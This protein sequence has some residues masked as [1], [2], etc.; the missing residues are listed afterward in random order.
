PRTCRDQREV[1]EISIVSLDRTG[2]RSSKNRR[3]RTRG[4]P[5]LIGRRFSGD[6]STPRTTGAEFDSASPV[7][8]ALYSRPPR[9]RKFG[10]P[11]RQP[12][13]RLA[14]NLSGR[15]DS[16]PRR[17]AWEA[18]RRPSKVVDK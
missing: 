11:G 13:K 16:N 18:G 15:W 2:G 8:A 1:S 14:V 9:A 10:Q 12:R 17:R 5:L 7:F 3:D 6:F 4:H